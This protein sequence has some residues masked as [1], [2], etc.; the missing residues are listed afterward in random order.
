MSEVKP[1]ACEVNLLKYPG[2]EDWAFARSAGVSETV[3]RDMA[4]EEHLYRFGTARK[5]AA[6]LDVKPV[7][8]FQG[9]GK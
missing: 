7:V 6:A 3:L 5:I 2:A 8:L 4:D 1:L 9:C